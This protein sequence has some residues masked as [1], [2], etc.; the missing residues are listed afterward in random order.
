MSKHAVAGWVSLWPYLFICS[1]WCQPWLVRT[2]HVTV[3]GLATALVWFI[4]IM[5][6]DFA[7]F[8]CC[9]NDR[10]YAEIF[11]DE[12]MRFCWCGFRCGW[13]VSLEDVV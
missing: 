6:L 5:I 13:V 1:W 9:M 10:L 7:M 12:K 11:K 8:A 3:L 2:F 4:I